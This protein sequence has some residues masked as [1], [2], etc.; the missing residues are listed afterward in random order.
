MAFVF[1]AM[2]LALNT[3]LNTK[4]ATTVANR[5]SLVVIFAPSVQSLVNIASGRD[6]ASQSN[7]AKRSFFFFKIPGAVA[8]GYRA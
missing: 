4:S 6:A 1:A 3:P 8:P 7:G 2:A 5:A